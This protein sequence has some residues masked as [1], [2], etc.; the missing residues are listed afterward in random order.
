MAFYICFN[1]TAVWPWRLRT[2]LVGEIRAIIP[3]SEGA[4]ELKEVMFLFECLACV[5]GRGRD[6]P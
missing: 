3:T 6:P 1:L 2:F 4:G 5:P